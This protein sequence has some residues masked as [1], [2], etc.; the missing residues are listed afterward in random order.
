M[1]KPQFPHRPHGRRSN[2]QELPY[3]HPLTR[4][5]L[6][7]TPQHQHRLRPNQLPTKPI[8]QSFSR[9]PLHRLRNR[10]LTRPLLPLGRRTCHITS[11]RHLRCNRPHSLHNSV[12]ILIRHLCPVCAPRST[13]LAYH[14]PL[15]S[16][17]QW[18]TYLPSP[19]PELEQGI[20]VARLSLLVR[21]WLRTRIRPHLR[22]WPRR[23]PCH[24]VDTVIPW[25][26][27]TNHNIP[28]TTLC[29]LNICTNNLINMA[30]ILHPPTNQ[31]HLFP[32]SLAPQLRHFME[33]PPCHTLSLTPLIPLGHLPPYPPHYLHPPP[34]TH[35]ALTRT[36][37]PSFLAG[38]L[39]RS[40]SRTY[41]GRK[42]DV[43]RPSRRLE[44]K[45]AD[46]RLVGEFFARAASNGQCTLEVF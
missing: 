15:H 21:E 16:P 28:G 9:I 43:L 23:Y 4:V 8:L 44:S 41:V 19:V 31:V 34:L 6:P 40:L 14:V 45:D 5:R 29:P 27:I 42:Q 10:L 32:C 37:V 2:L 20:P 24:G 39:Q 18:P 13:V 17:A 11:H 12:H 38:A 46:A 30:L 33:Y 22:A 26:R 3:H 36:P 25:T 7:Q 35:P 1:A